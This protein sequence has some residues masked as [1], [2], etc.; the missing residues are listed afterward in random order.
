MSV[1]LWIFGALSFYGAGAAATGYA[2]V[3]AG[4]R[5]VSALDL[6]TGYAVACVFWPVGMWVAVASQALNR[7]ERIEAEKRELQ[8]EAER[9]MRQEGMR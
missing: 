2:L 8:R 4:K 9:L 6:P 7:V 1:L 5:L 3:R